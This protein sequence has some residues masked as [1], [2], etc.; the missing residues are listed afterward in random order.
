[1]DIPLIGSPSA[2]YKFFY[3]AGGS[4]ILSLILLLVITSYSAVMVGDA[5]TLMK[6]MHDVLHGVKE[7]LPEAKFGADML[8]LLCEN[9]NFTNYYPNVRPICAEHK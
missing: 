5:N 7:L 9:K 1:M 4:I 8:G 6:E 3:T 2:N